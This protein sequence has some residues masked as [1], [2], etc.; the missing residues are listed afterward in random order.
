MVNQL[1]VQKF[2]V[3]EVAYPV[4]HR[5]F[6]QKEIDFVAAIKKD[7]F[8]KRDV[9]ELGVEEANP[10][11]KS[12][13]KRGI[14]SIVDEINE[15]YKISDF[16]GRLDIFSISE[17][18]TYR[19][20]TKEERKALDE[21]YFDEYYNGLEQ[22]PNVR[23][24]QDEILPLEEVLSFIDKQERSVYLNYCDCRSLSG[25]CGMPTKTCITYRNGINSFVHRG[26]SEE[27]TKEAAKEIVTLADK[28][29]LMHTVNPN[30]IC[31]CCNDCCYL[32]RA[33]KRRDSA[34]FWPKTDHVIE[35]DY[36][37]C[38]SCGK[39]MRTCH[40]K[41]FEKDGV[42]RADQYKCVGCG[43]CVRVCPVGALQLVETL[44]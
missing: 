43:I 27:I 35:L 31:N 8:S 37:K 26:L 39:C 5:M 40:F 16:Y 4:I 15:T 20:F 1:F 7:V 12:C 32:F 21:W 2:Q 3:P 22:D 11:L 34:G 44:I 41:V 30:G 38:I 13:Y 18:D 23:P 19:S 14:I 42:V 29:G 33:Q 36:N 24:T 6:T 25:D 9:E 28:T 10:F 17:T